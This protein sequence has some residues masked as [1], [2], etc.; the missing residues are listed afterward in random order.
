VRIE[1]SNT[2]IEPPG[3]VGLGRQRFITFSSK[4]FKKRLRGI[5]TGARMIYNESNK[6]Y[7]YAK[8]GQ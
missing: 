5:E 7:R 8:G 4:G 6:G 1:E 3:Q 2:Y